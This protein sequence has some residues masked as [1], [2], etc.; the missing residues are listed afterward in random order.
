[1]FRFILYTCM[2]AV[3]LLAAGC[4][5]SVSAGPSQ[6]LEN[7]WCSLAHGIARQIPADLHDVERN[8]ALS[9][10]AIT[11]L[12]L[13][14]HKQA[15]EI[16][17]DISGWRRGDLLAR[18]GHRC[19]ATGR[20]DAGD[21]FLKA[22]ENV[23]RDSGLESWQRS[24]I[25]LAIER[26]HAG[27]TATQRIEAARV[28]RLDTADQA[29]LLPDLMQH[30]VATSNLLDTLNR[31]ETVSRQTLDL[32]L[33]AGAFD[34]YRVAYQKAGEAGQTAL[35][36][37]RLA[38]GLTRLLD[39][40][41]PAVVCDKLMEMSEAARRLGDTPFAEQMSRET[42]N[43]LG[44]IRADMRLPVQTR[45]AR[46]LARAGDTRQ[47]R[48]RLAAA[49]TLLPDPAITPAER[50]AAHAELGAA[51]MELGDAAAADGHFADAI[52]ALKT[53][54]NSRPRAVAAVRVCLTFARAGIAEP[55]RLSEMAA[56]L[57]RLG[58]PW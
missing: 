5:P 35:Y 38:A 17:C 22:A 31:L 42:G 55:A 49:E 46:L 26:A 56:L 39:S 9:D 43:R 40:L 29:A 32:D 45:Y 2:L 54:A 4:R 44:L 11:A 21:R 34:A 53:L 28:T 41:H 7:P 57:N 20:G 37:D 58:D 52:L 51:W 24:R 18:L 8:R 1:M 48:R 25:R 14:A 36:R 3:A 19:H 16:A 12:D 10:T 50:A 33:A 47:A 15:A 6:P 13:G 30:T 27:R 23:A